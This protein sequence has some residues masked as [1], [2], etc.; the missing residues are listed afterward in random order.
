MFYD[1]KGTFSIILI[2]I[3]DADYKFLYANVGSYG[4]VGDAGVFQ[5]CALNYNLQY[6]KL[7]IPKSELL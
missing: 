5:N 2:A 1:Y 3:V 4:S 6:N 7:N